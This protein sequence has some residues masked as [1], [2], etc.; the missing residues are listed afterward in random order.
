MKFLF[1]IVFVFIS[2]GSSNDKT[3]DLNVHAYT[4]SKRYIPSLNTS[5]HWQLQ[6]NINTSYNV[7]IYDIDLFDTSADFIKNLHSQGK[8]V[9]CYFSAGTYENYRI[10]KND[11]P[12]H[13]LGKTMEDWEEEKWLDIR[14]E[15]LIPIMGAR[16]DLAV[17]KGC[18]GIELDNIDAYSNDSGFDLSYN[19]Q[20]AYNKFLANESRKRGLS[21]GLKNDLNQIKDLIEYFDFAVNEQCF[22]YNECEYLKIFIDNG[23]AVFNAEYLQ[24]YKSNTEEQNNL[25]KK[26]KKFKFN[27]LVLDIDL[28]DKYRFSC[29]WNF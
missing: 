11:F 20:L 17:I 21:V 24:K 18:D 1:L 19:D 3:F 25:C 22:E 4:K 8:K 26:A 13:I 29:N 9:I 28:N 14:S 16:L 6:G 10:D 2:C 27:T 15:T 7:E 12:K 5:W 23:K